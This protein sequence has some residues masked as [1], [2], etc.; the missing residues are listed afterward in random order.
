MTSREVA[1]ALGISVG[2]VHQVVAEGAMRP[3]APG[4]GYFTR[5]EVERFARK[6]KRRAG[7]VLNLPD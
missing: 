2:R 6:R 1:A 3:I 5:T 7:I 4:A